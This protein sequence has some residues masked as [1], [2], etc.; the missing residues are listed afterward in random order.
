MLAIIGFAIWWPL[1]LMVFAYLIWSGKM[2]CCGTGFDHWSDRAE[3]VSPARSRSSPPVSGNS[4]F[5]EYRIETVRRLEEEQREFRAF[6]DRLRMAKDK[7][8]FDQ[9]MSERRSGFTGHRP[10]VGT[11]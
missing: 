3:N 5:D 4:A 6:L 11:Q 1:G 8:E 9:F 7:T 10:S 2:W